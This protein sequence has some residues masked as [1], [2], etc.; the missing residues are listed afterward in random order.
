MTDDEP[1]VCRDCGMPAEFRIDEGLWRHKGK[2]TDDKYF[3]QTFC[4]RYGYP[5]RVEVKKE[6]IADVV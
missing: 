5:I 2:V 3:A 1:V 4:E 6:K